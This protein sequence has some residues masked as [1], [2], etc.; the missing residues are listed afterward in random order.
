MAFARYVPPGRLAQVTRICNVCGRPYEAPRSTSRFCGDTCRKRNLRAPRPRLA[1]VRGDTCRNRNLRAPRPRPVAQVRPVAA[2]H[3]LLDAV[4]AELEAAG[5]LDS[6]LGQVALLLATRICGVYDT[7]SGTATMAAALRDAPAA[8]DPVD[9]L[10]RRRDP[11]RG[12]DR[13][14]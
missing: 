6:A 7:G 3:P 2:D 14:V 5:R 13:A 12:G 11:K 10:R 1:E 8:A 9:E 4:R